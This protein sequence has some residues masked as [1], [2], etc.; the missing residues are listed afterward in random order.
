MY[1]LCDYD[2]RLPPDLIAQVPLARRDQSRLMV[3]QKRTGAISHHRFADLTAWL[4]R[5]D[6][7][8][9]NNTRVIQSRLS[10]T[11]ETGGKIEV[12]L[13][14][15]PQNVR[16]GNVACQCLV[17]ASKPPR[18]GS[19]I[20]FDKNLT[21]TVLEGG[22]GLFKMAF[23]VRGDFDA[24]LQDVGQVPLP[25]YI[26]RNGRQAVPCDDR[27]AYQTVYA[28]KKGAVAAPTAG[29]HFTDELLDALC[30]KG[31]A[32]V[33]VTLHVSYGTF[34]P[35]RVHDI[36]KHK[37]HAEAYE[38]TGEA[39]SAINAAKARGRRVIAVGTTSVRLLEYAADGAGHARPGA[40]KCDLFIYPG[41]DFKVIDGVIT[42]FHLPQSTLL[43]LVSAF[44]GREFVLNAYHEAIE[45]KYRFY[46]YGD[47]MFII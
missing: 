42:N 35:V 18:P 23:D 44:A 1:R 41:F 37:M 13:L 43:M 12:L 34:V 22:S 38:L 14:D 11:K 3:L 9:V 39:A 4:H 8:V 5:D 24:V 46:S 10:G 7:L 30:K 29:L 36:R 26:R 16:A 20:Y 27:Q 2:Y 31:I 47:A 17:R 6:L 25:P 19:T 32:I 40:G 45:Q 33:S 28:E 21:A 15:Y